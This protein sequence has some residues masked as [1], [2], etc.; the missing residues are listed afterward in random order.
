MRCPRRTQRIDRAARTLE[1]ATVVVAALLL[2]GTIA[3]VAEIIALRTSV[4]AR[5]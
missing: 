4:N 1:W 2:F 5:R 3:G